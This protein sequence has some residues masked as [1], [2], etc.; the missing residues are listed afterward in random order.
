[1][2]TGLS[3][4]IHDKI[5]LLPKKS[6][7]R[8]GRNKRMEHKGGRIKDHISREKHPGQDDWMDV[9]W[10]DEED[11]GMMTEEP[12]EIWSD[13]SVN[14]TTAGAGTHMDGASAQ[15]DDEPF[16]IEDWRDVENWNLNQDKRDVSTPK[17]Q[18]QSAQTVSDSSNGKVRRRDP[19]GKSGELSGSGKR[20]AAG[21]AKRPETGNRKQPGSAGR[22]RTEAGSK[23][24]RQ[25]EK[26]RSFGENQS[27]GRAG[28]QSREN[29][30]PQPRQK[31]QGSAARPVKAAG[32][33]AGRAGKTAGRAVGK[34]VSIVLKC[35]S[36]AAMAIIVLK[37]WEEFWAERNTLGEIWRVAADRNYAEALYLGIAGFLLLF[38]ILSAIWLLGGKRMPDG[39]RLRSYDT[40]R[41]LTAFILFAILAA[42]AGFVIP[43]VPE[44]PQV[45]SGAKLALEVVDRADRIILGCSVAGIVLC[46]IRKLIRK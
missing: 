15:E 10:L 35:G 2:K 3:E 26:G 1:M 29:R 13:I 44:S 6:E 17:A 18:G 16:E 45:L 41:G 38:G 27:A 20:P 43:L 19:Q 40:G 5:L 21:E 12:T 36:F 4:I 30:E 22:K 46:V 31:K 14:E 32:R 33:A 24:G 37:L 25:T 9:E 28:Q 11:K 39:N 42:A 7:I 34:G 8:K 23:G